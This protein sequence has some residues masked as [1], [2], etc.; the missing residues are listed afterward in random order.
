VL[1]DSNGVARVIEGDDR[2]LARALSLGPPWSGSSLSSASVM[3][4]SGGGISSWPST[5][6]TARPAVAVREDFPGGAVQ[7]ALVSGG[8][9]GEVGEL[10]VGR[11]GLGDG[12]VAFQQGP[13][14]NAAIVAAHVSAPPAQFVVSTPNG[15]VKPSAAVV[16][17]EPA[18]SA[19][20]P[21]TYQLVL[22][23][24]G[25]RLPTPAG[26]FEM[27]VAAGALSSG[28]HEIRMLATDRDGAAT[29]TPPSG[30]SVDGQPPTVAIARSRRAGDVRVRV[31]DADSGVNARDVRVSFGDGARAAGRKRFAHRYARPGV[32]RI[33]VSA[34]D[35]VGNSVVVRRLVSVP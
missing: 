30:L 5:G 4:P 8:D 21:L 2:G 14:G 9:G 23:L 15:W 24:N 27:R 20:G 34:A 35:N 11:S 6:P 1:Y 31:R 18:P 19:A 10:A 7:T 28:R 17:W 25:R 22:V 26:A 3:N 29:L 12:L 33:V 16:S 13:L 32:Y